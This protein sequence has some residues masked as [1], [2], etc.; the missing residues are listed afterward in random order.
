MLKIL[1]TQTI[2]VI[3]LDVRKDKFRPRIQIK[4]FLVFL[5]EILETVTVIAV[6]PVILVRIARAD[7]KVTNSMDVVVMDT[8][9]EGYLLLEEKR[10]R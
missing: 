5:E 7:P 4:S 10:G 2:S 9:M 8:L 6:V 1:P 3:A